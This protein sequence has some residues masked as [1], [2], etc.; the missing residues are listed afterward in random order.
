[1]IISEEF[2]GLSEDDKRTL[3]KQ[4]QFYQDHKKAIAEGHGKPVTNPR[5][6]GHAIGQNDYDPPTVEGLERLKRY[7]RELADKRD[8]DGSSEPLQPGS[9]P[10]KV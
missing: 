9:D 4:R 3:A 10:E 8:S 5:L 2:E 6:E 1:M 7:G